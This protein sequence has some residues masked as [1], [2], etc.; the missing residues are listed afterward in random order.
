VLAIAILCAAP[1]LFEIG[2]LLSVY[3]SFFECVITAFIT[4]HEPTTLSYIPKRQ[5]CKYFASPVALWLKSWGMKLAKRI[6]DF[7]HSGAPRHRKRCKYYRTSSGKHQYKLQAN[8]KGLDKSL[9]TDTD[10]FKSTFASQRTPRTTDSSY[11][12]QIHLPSP[13][14]TVHPT[15]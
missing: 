6:D 3:A 2:W 1:G 4:I 12:T 14:T 8:Q 13:S 10:K 15:A 5:Q 9:S 11:S 7:I